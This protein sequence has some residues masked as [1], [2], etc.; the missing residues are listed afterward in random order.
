[1]KKLVFV[2]PQ[3]KIIQFEVDGRKVKYFDEVWKKG[4][5]ILP[6]DERLI[7]EMKESGS[8]NVRVMAALILDANKGENLREYEECNT[9][10]EIVNMIRNDCKGKGLL[11]A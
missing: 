1:M 10:E 3:R 11:E 2:G 5:Q 7:K 8:I 9:E 6:K 4:I